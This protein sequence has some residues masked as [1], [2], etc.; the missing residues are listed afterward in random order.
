MAALNLPSDKQYAPIF[1]L[2][3]SSQS[4]QQQHI[5]YH[6]MSVIE[7]CFEENKAVG[8]LEVLP[9]LITKYQVRRGGTLIHHNSAT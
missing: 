4:S 9:D 5:P 7:I 2:P 8:K 1:L 6:S 3:N